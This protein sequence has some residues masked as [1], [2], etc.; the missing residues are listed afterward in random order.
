MPMTE[1]RTQRRLAA[2]GVF[3][4]LAASI[5]KRR[6][7][8]GSTLPPERELSA[9][10]DV[11]RLIA[12]QALHRLRDMGLVS[13]GQGGKSV[14]LDPDASNDLRLVALTMQLAPERTD[15]QDVI[16]RQLLGGAM[17]IDL[18]E[19]R[20]DAEALGALD[21]LVESTLAGPRDKESIR[22]AEATFW[23]T[24]AEATGNRILTR[25]ARYWF[26]VMASQKARRDALYEVPELR[27]M[28]YRA[29]I[30]D[31][32]NGRPAADNFRA[33]IKPLLTARRG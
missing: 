28:A 32:K 3:E 5:L 4:A 17:L 13:G 15:E 23:I 30:D 33:T 26:D 24:L 21:R 31:L 16:E 2:D 29:I 20:I 1:R 25:E 19:S 9:L 27:L 11:S 6:Y 22:A 7:P 18:A 8:P 12:R 14:V 10:Y